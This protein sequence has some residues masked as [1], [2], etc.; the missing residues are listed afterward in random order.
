MKKSIV[1]FVIAKTS[2][3]YH[4]VF[5]FYIKFCMNGIFLVEILIT[6]WFFHIYIQDPSIYRAVVLLN[7]LSNKLDIFR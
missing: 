2:L 6:V 3:P 4:F 5:V 7:F 1:C